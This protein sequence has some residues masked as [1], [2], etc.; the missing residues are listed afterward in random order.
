MINF[1]DILK[2]KKGYFYFNDL[3]IVKKSGSPY[4]LFS[5]QY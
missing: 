5:V 3:A 4:T 1:K 2:Q